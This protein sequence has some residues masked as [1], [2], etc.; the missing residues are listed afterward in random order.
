MRATPKT[1]SPDAGV[2]S[3][4]L[5]GEKRELP[6]L[7]W[8]PKDMFSWAGRAAFFGGMLIVVV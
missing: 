3:T 1:S 6:S 5:E 7:T 4:V 8:G 2:S